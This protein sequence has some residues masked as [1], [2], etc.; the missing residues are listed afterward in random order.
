MF[1]TWCLSRGETHFSYLY[2]TSKLEEVPP[3]VSII[4]SYRNPEVCI[5]QLLEE[6]FWVVGDSYL[7][8]VEKAFTVPSFLK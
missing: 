5:S 2:D 8:G 6:T 7:E 1:A 3:K 4:P